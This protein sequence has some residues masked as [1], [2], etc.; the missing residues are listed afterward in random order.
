[1]QL[2]EMS[3]Q[4][5]WA[6]MQKAIPEDVLRVFAQTSTYDKLPQFL[7]ENREY[8]SR[9]GVAMPASTPAQRERLAH[10]MKEVQKVPVTGVPR[11]LEDLGKVDAK[12]RV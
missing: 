6:E 2:H 3:L 7:A 5:K 11:G 12:S 10:V 1:M 4:G 9:I 8:A